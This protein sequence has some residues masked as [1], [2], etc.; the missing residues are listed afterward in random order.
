MQRI[1]SYISPL[2]GSVEG[3]D[4]MVFE[5][6]HGTAHCRAQLEAGARTLERAKF[7]GTAF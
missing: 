3:R 4:G 1:S 2:R 6:P 7:T 5:N